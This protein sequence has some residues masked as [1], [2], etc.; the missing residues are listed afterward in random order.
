MYLPKQRIRDPFL[1]RVQYSCDSGFFGTPGSDWLHGCHQGI[2]LAL[3]GSPHLMR[4]PRKNSVHLCCH[5]KGEEYVPPT[6]SV[7]MFTPRPT[8]HC[9]SLGRRDKGFPSIVHEAVSTATIK[10]GPAAVIRMTT[11]P[12]AN[13]GIPTRDRGVLHTC[14]YAVFWGCGAEKVQDGQNQE[15]KIGTVLTG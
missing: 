4:I 6:E 15:K 3:L 11:C 2:L 14:S 1:S 8:A 9:V 13:R 10:V 5:P 7:S 12:A